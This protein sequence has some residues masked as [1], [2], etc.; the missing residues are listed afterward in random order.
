MNWGLLVG[1]ANKG[2]S[3]IIER[4]S[5]CVCE[6]LQGSKILVEEMRETKVELIP[7]AK[8]IKKRAYKLAHK[9]IKNS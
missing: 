3:E 9:Y 5:S 4:I 6:G 2:Y 1:K 8:I 7:R